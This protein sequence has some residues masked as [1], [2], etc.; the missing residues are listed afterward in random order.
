MNIIPV[1]LSGGAGTRLWPVSREAYPKPFLKMSDGH[2]LLLKTYQRASDV[3]KKYTDNSIL[4][5]TNR[6]YFFMSKDEI[7]KVSGI[8]GCFLL[9]P[10]G[11]NTAPAIGLASFQIAEKYG[12]DAIIL[13]LSAD[14]LIQ[15]QEK[16]E[17]AVDDAIELAK[18]NYLAVFGIK[19]TSPETGFGYIEAGENIEGLSNSKKV[20]RFVEKPNKEKAEEYLQTQRY[21]WNSGM[22]CFKAQTFLNELKKCNI[23]VY[24]SVEECWNFIDGNCKK[25]KNSDFIEIPNELFKKVPDISID[26]AVMELSN[27]VAV[28]PAEFD[29][30]DIGSWA[31]VGELVP[32]DEKG[33]K[34]DCKE[35]VFVE[36]TNIYARSD[37]RLIATVGVDNLII[38][39]TP[40]A[41]L[42]ANREKVQDVKQVVA[43][44]KQL[45]NQ[46]YKL[47]QTVHRPWGT[48]TILGE[49]ANFKI[50]RIE[51]KPGAT[52]SLQMHHHRSEHWIVVRGMAKVVNG[53]NEFFI[54]ANESTYINAGC[55]HRLEN[56]GLVDL[57]M[58]EVQ[59]GEY[60]GE[61]DIVRYQDVYGRA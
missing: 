32:S 3:I 41:V 15:D 10:E 56:P 33:N 51:V 11:R 39:D 45:G 36:S 49:G 53:E 26:Y 38:V 47:H 29:W 58:I 44:L 2:S 55:K 31:A 4:T 14:H 12:A 46:A 22:F 7:Q 13:V 52:L 43:Q 9:E 16:F 23:D 1:I 5:V 21:L 25:F 20:I 61:D 35:S 6:D 40:D 60:L 34:K 59:S 19:P 8:E 17:Q 27:K 37:D 50:K 30:S 57:V 54:R 18:N 28:V 48:Y 42:V 24:S